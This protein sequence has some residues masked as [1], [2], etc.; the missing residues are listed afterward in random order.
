MFLV[1]TGEIIVHSVIFQGS[2]HSDKEQNFLRD[3]EFFRFYHL[4]DYWRNGF[5]KSL[6][7]GEGLGSPLGLS[8]GL[9]QNKSEEFLRR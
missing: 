1:R 3:Q 7:I 9:D 4:R 2:N 8:L 6:D 5:V